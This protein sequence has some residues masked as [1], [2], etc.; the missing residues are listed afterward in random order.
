MTKAYEEHDSLYV[1][2]DCII[3]GFDGTE[4][5]ALLVKRALEP[6]KGKWS[7]MGGFVGAKESVHDAASRVLENLT[8]LDNIYM[9]Q[10]NC[11]GDVKRD[12]AGRVVSIAYFA[13]IKLDDYEEALLKKHQANWFSLN[14]IPTV[15]FDHKEMITLS[16]ERLRQKAIAYP[17][18]FELLPA[19]FTMQQLQALYEAVYNTHFDKRN[20]TKKILSLN[21]LNRLTE[22]EKATSRK[23]SFLYMFDKKKYN[24]LKKQGIKLL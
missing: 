5:K 1:A 8:G 2:V 22:K 16:L 3:F 11:F 13:L 18:G 4:I 9:E 23:G 20:F 14:R 24:Q 15:V 17:I 6:E 21:L 10:L 7:L 19:K 12:E